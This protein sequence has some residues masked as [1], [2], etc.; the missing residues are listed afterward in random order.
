MRRSRGAHLEAASMGQRPALL[1]SGD[2]VQQST[3]AAR[4]EGQLAVI[5]N[6]TPPTL[7]IGA[8]AAGAE[9][10]SEP[11]RSSARVATHREDHRNQAHPVD[12]GD[13]RKVLLNCAARLATECGDARVVRSQPELDSPDWTGRRMLR[14]ADPSAADHGT[15][16]RCGQRDIPRRHSGRHLSSCRLLRVL[17]GL[18]AGHVTRPLFRVVLAADAAE[19]AVDTGSLNGEKGHNDT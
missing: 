12:H 1:R 3:L 6:A 5:R 4:A 15:A 17:G 8:A 19:L 16:R 14:L 13:R 11:H 2:L 9:P 7:L 10:A 18:E